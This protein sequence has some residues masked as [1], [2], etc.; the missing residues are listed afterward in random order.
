MGKVTL[1][2]SLCFTL[3]STINSQVVINELLPDP[4]PSVS[5]PA[6]EFIELHNIS[7][8][9]INLENYTLSDPT[10]SATLPNYM[11]NVNAY[12]IICASGNESAFSPFGNVIGVSNFPS[13]NN[14]GD[15]I[16]LQDNNAI[17]LSQIDYAN[18]WYKDPLKDNGG[19]ALERINPLNSCDGESN[20]QASLNTNGGSPGIEN[21]VFNPSFFDASEIE[22]LG[23]EITNGNTITIQ[24]SKKLNTADAEDISNYSIL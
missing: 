22:I 6:E 18:N 5:L 13:L 12:L 1:L 7:A 3:V 17:I 21:S 2:I 16:T 8:S 20:W 11:L 4:N 19:W 23:V 24:L 14:S 9:A 15:V 10:R